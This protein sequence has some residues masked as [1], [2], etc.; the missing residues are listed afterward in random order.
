MFR[1][2]ITI[3]NKP[4]SLFKLR[5]NDMHQFMIIRSMSYKLTCHP[6]LNSFAPLYRRKAMTI[7]EY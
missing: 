4:L 6:A 2:P 1:R 7:D 3:R 5:H